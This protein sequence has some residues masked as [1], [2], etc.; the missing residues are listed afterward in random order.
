MYLY[1]VGEKIKNKR[2]MIISLENEIDQDVDKCSDGK[3]EA[4]GPERNE[5]NLGGREE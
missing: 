5:L 3:I 2:P 1:S 4:V